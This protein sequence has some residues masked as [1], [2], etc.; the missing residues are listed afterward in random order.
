MIQCVASKMLTTDKLSKSHTNVS[1]F[2][3]RGNSLFF[4]RSVLAIIATSSPCSL[5]IGSLPKIKANQ[6]N[7]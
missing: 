6:Q 3:A 7:T 1:S 4:L 2:E 5:M